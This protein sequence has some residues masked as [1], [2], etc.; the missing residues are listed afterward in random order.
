MARRDMKWL[1]GTLRLNK[2]GNKFK[3]DRLLKEPIS[4]R[5][6]KEGSQKNL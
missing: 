3:T 6:G 1:K 2:D 4:T 5:V